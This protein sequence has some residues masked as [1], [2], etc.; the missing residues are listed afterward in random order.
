MKEELTRRFVRLKWNSPSANSGSER[1]TSCDSR[2]S[3][4]ET[5]PHSD[6]MHPS[7]P[8]GSPT[9]CFFCMPILPA[10]WRAYSAF[11]SMMALGVEAQSLRRRS[12]YLNTSFPL[13]H[14]KYQPSLSLELKS[15]STAATVFPLT[16]Q[17]TSE[18]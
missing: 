16:N 14:T 11:T 13:V 10:R 2:Q 18:R 9:F 5:N 3:R 8:Q 1:K 4:E 7:N 17:H 15:P 12:S 6:L